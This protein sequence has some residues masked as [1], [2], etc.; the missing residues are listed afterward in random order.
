M[1]ATSIFER[2]S[3]RLIADV[4]DSFDAA[5]LARLRCYFAGGTRIAIDLGEF[6]ESRDIDFLCSDAAA[7][8]ELRFAIRERGYPALFRSAYTDRLTFPRQP[9][10][11]QYGIRFPA[12]IAGTT[13]RIELIREARVELGEPVFPTW[14]GVPCIS[15]AD[16]Y[17]EKLLANS[18]R[19]ADHDTLARDLIDLAAL[20]ERHGPIPD[21][22]W[23][24]A[25]NAYRAAI[26]SDLGKA[27]RAFLED[28]AFRTRC[29]RGLA[30][31]STREDGLT[32]AVNLLLAETS[33]S[34][35]ADT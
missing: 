2:P 28:A 21:S 24:A 7:Y 18:D 29:F 25:E 32:A 12:V 1:G 16:C 23:N 6:R 11:D 3:H 20:R 27:A 19:W 5:A 33:S 34:A 22:S 9:R 30:I 13:L 26:R 8:A 4:L 31:E 15:I 14:T 10:S 35:A 17:T